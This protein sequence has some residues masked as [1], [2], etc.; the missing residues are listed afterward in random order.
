MPREG[1]AIE[2]LLLRLFLPAVLVLTLLLA[3]LVYTSLYATIIDRFDRK[4]ATTSALAGALVDPAGHDELIAAA[5][6]GTPEAT[7]RS[8]A[9]RRDAVPMQRIRKTLGLTYL[10][11]QTLGPSQGVTY[12]LDSSPGD[13]HS[14]IGSTDTLPDETMIGLRRSQTLGSIYVSPIEFQEKWGLL[15]TA[16]APVY[17]QAGRITASAGADVNISIINVAT[18]NALFASAVIGI[19]SILACIVVV[20]AIVRRIGRPIEALRQEALRIAAGDHRPPAPLDSPREVKHLRARLA[21]LTAR[22]A[23]AIDRRRAAAARHEHA[24]NLATLARAAEAGKATSIVPLVR[25]AEEQV[26]WIARSEASL[27]TRLA[28]RAMAQLA[29]QIA[30][31][32]ALAPHWPIL[33]DLQYGT[34]L[35]LDR[36]PGAIEV[37]G[38][39]SL[40]LV[41]DGQS[42]R[43]TDRQGRTGASWQRVSLLMDGR[44]IALDGQSA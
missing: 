39:D 31:D 2:T 43:L 19:G 16:S 25:V 20:L 3:V 32:R 22:M 26:W 15:K 44:E 30:V 38:E 23:Q 24:A 17:G 42:V 4:L 12:I 8:A 18:Q 41:V 11:T 27:E 10:Y 6:R 1:I 28:G 21:A 40:N 7:E 13:D 37:L 9:Y 5:G 29:R 14:P 34:C 36:T 33:A 35:R